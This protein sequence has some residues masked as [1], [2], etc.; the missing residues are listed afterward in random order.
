LFYAFE[1]EKKLG[2][3]LVLNFGRGMLGVWPWVLK[4]S[5]SKNGEKMIIALVNDH[6]LEGMF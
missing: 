3:S 2:A 1:M 5:K 4:F 6:G